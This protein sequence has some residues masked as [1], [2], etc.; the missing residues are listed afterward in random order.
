M[1]RN[2]VSAQYNFD[3]D[4]L[5]YIASKYIRT[6]HDQLYTASAGAIWNA[7]E[8]GRLSTTMLY[9]NGLRAG[10]ANTN[11]LP[12]YATANLGA[13]QE[14]EIAGTGKWQARFDILNIANTRY[15]LRDG[16]GVGVGAPAY[17]WRRGVYAGLSKLF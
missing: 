11:K 8:G 1:A 5:A 7:W 9:G 4:E 2:I 16:T 14:F 12:P 6:D 13:Q 3:P 15:I 17:G 10:F